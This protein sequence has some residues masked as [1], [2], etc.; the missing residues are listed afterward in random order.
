[1]TGYFGALMRASGLA[2][3]GP[4]PSIALS[5]PPIAGNDTGGREHVLS[6]VHLDAPPR[7][8]PRM[9]PPRTTEPLATA[10]IPVQAQPPDDVRD[11]LAGT[12]AMPVPEPAPASPIALTVP[13]ER[14]E[15]PPPAPREAPPQLADAVVRAA[16]RWVATDPQTR[17]QV[18]AVEQPGPGPTP[19]AST[20]GMPPR[21]APEAPTR[22]EPPPVADAAA[23]P[24]LS[25]RTPGPAPSELT[26]IAARAIEP[27]PRLPIAPRAAERGGEI[28]EVSIGAI[29][30]RVDAP[31]A[32]TVARPAAAPA[33]PQRTAVHSSRR[34]ALSRRAL[35][36]I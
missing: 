17:P 19:A 1:M 3:A 23:P 30:V 10:A 27:V 14:R 21:P 26:E 25:P 11:G 35:R 24:A 20:E 34:G 9:G 22:E 29:H 4:V 13:G 18:R 7:Q 16:M 15:A 2:V 36:R 31:A 32:Q 12:P 33:A 8:A 5:A 6:P 28:L